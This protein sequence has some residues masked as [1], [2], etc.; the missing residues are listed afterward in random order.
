MKIYMIKDG[1]LI[2]VDLELTAQI[3][4]S[5]GYVRI[6]EEQAIGFLGIEQNKARIQ[7][8]KKLLLETDWKVIVNAER[9]QAGLELK[10]PNLHSE[11]QAWRDEINTL[12]ELI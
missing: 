12:E 6:T 2:S 10:Y 9:L 7:E 11:R 5:E 1:D 8:L 4:E 3:M